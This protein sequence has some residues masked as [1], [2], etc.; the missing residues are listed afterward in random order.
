MM[1]QKYSC[2]SAPIKK[3]HLLI[4]EYNEQNNFEFQKEKVMI[5][6]NKFAQ[7]KN[8]GKHNFRAAMECKTK[9]CFNWD[10]SKCT[11]TDQY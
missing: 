3:G 7:I 4:G 5:D 11:V 1:E 9:G 2:P 6:S 8:Q 10:G